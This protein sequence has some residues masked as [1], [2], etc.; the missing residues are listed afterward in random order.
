MLVCCAQSYD[1][2]LDLASRGDDKN[3]NTYLQDIKQET[4]AEGLEGDSNYYSAFCKADLNYLIFFFGKGVNSL[5]GKFL[6]VWFLE[7]KYVN[8]PS[9]YIK[10]TKCLMHLSQH[11][12]NKL[13]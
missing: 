10:L 9:K 11:M 1:E 13:A 5:P 6:N 3:V 2:F 7:Q 8:F 4:A 12:L